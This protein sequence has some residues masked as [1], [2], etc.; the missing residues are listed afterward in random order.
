[1]SKRNPRPAVLVACVLLLA[2]AMLAAAAC[3]L[4]AADGRPPDDAK[5]GDADIEYHDADVPGDTPGP[6]VGRTKESPPPDAVAGFLVLSNGDRLAGQ[7]HLTRDAVL[8]F[9]DPKREKLLRFRLDELTHIEQKPVVERMEK[10]WRW[11]ENANDEKVYTGREYPV[12][13][14]VTVLHLK[15]GPTL[16]GPMNAL[17]WVTNENGSQRFLLHKRQKGKPGTTLKELLYVKLVDLRPTAKN[18]APDAEKP[19]AEK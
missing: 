14:L 11:L 17:L 13:E 1:M 10:E 7:V 3:L 8:K 15:R 5:K 12:R 2:C 19:P 9:F 18:D 16:E 6:P 4:A